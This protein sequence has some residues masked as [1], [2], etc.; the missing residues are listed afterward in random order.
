MN[1]EIV[2]IQNLRFEKLIIL[3][4]KIENLMYN[5]YLLVIIIHIL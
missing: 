5:L 2:V 4:G 1:I 3:F